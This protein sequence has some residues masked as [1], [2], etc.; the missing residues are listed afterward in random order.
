MAKEVGAADGGADSKVGASSG[1]GKDKP[2]IVVG[3]VTESLFYA[4]PSK[5][6]EAHVMISAFPVMFSKLM[7]E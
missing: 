6:P 2:G 3:R 4:R 7:P 5:P 1:L